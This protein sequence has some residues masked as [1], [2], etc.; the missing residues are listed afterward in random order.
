[1]PKI[2]IFSC[3]EDIDSVDDSISHATDWDEVTDDELAKLRHYIK[4]KNPGGNWGYR[5]FLV[6][7][8]ELNTKHIVSLSIE[9]YKQKA[10]EFKET[11]IK[12]NALAKKKKDNKAKAKIKADKKKLV[13]LKE[14]YDA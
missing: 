10:V 9:D 7:V 6:L 5:E 12:K 11:E 1:M 2:K 14:K 4:G 8:E 13:E 3:T